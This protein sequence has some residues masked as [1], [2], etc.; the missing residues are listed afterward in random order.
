MNTEVWAT[1]SCL[2]YLKNPYGAFVSVVDFHSPPS[3]S[4][5]P[6]ISVLRYAFILLSFFLLKDADENGFASAFL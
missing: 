3:S 1:L 2:G 5:P 6:H 4:P